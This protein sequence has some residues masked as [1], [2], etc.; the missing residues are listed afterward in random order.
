MCRALLQTAEGIGLVVT[1]VATG[2]TLGGFAPD[3]RSYAACVPDYD[4]RHTAP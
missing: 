2:V 3:K 4:Y 1:D